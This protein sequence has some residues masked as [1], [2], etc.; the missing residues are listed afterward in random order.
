MLRII[1]KIETQYG[2]ELDEQVVFNIGTLEQL[3]AEV[4]RLQ[5]D[6]APAEQ[7]SVAS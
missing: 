3:V 5:V 4:V 1:T 6:D 2:I 7:R